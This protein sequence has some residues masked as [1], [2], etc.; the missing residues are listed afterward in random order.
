LNRFRGFGL[1]LTLSGAVL[2]IVTYLLLGIVPLLALWIAFTVLGLS[3][4]LTPEEALVKPNLLAV[5]EDS[6]SNLSSLFESFGA[7]SYATYVCYDTGVYVFVSEEPLSSFPESPPKSLLVNVGSSRAFVL[8][9]PLSSI[10]GD[11]SGDFPSISHHVL[12]ELLEVADGVECSTA[13]EAI[14]CLVKKPYISSPARLEKTV[15]SIYGMC[16]A[17][18]ASKVYARPITLIRE[19]VS[20]KGRLVILR[21]I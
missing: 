9:S 7:S 6:L 2:S 17:S 14:S 8:R 13:G 11:L 3:M 19:E 4:F 18:I 5:V 16:L 12:V 21:M 1:S 20:E 15:G 10:I